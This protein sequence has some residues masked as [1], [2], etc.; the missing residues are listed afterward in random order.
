[1]MNIAI[2]RDTVF[3]WG[4]YLYSFQQLN[5]LK[6]FWEILVTN[7]QNI[8]YDII[9]VDKIKGGMNNKSLITWI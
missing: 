8:I 4:S 6:S 1:M 2:I 3:S 5:Y 9:T 7:I